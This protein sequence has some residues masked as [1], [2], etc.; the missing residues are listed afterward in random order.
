VWGS[1]ALQAGIACGAESIL[2]PEITYD[3]NEVAAKLQRG[4]DR[5]KTHSIIIVAE[6]AGSAYMMGEE[7]NKLSGFETRVTILGHLQRGGKPSALDAVIA[8]TMGAKAVE[9]LMS[10]QTEM[11]TAYLNQEVIAVPIEVAYGPKRPLNQGL[12]DLANELAI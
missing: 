12:Y 10:G 1:I 11:M 6:G 2:V 3:L 5:G 7:L 4:Y 9:I 8:T